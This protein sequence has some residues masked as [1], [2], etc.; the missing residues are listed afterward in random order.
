MAGRLEGKVAIVTGASRGLGEYCARQYGAEGATVVVAARTEKE[1]D[2]RLPGTI[3]SVAAGIEAAGGKAAAI[4]CNVSDLTS[5]EA[6]VKEVVERFGRI[7]VVMNNAGILPPGDLSSI[8]IKHWEL[9]VKVNL[10]G[11]FYV[12]RAVLPTMLSQQ[13]G[14]VIN[15]SSVASDRLSGAYGVLKRALEGMTEAF[16]REHAKNGIAFNAL[17]PVGAIETPGM[18]FGG[19]DPSRFAELPSADSYVEAAVL[20]ALQTPATCTGEAFNDAEAVARFADAETKRRLGV[21]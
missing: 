11:P 21:G 13:S 4:P 15:I 20:L 18:R 9:E 2:P 8:Q 17:K 19:G 12:T 1:T 5:V 6:M 7:D 16:A 14:S 10:N 3:Y